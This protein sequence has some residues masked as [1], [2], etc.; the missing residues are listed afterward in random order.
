MTKTEKVYVEKVQVRDLPAHLRDPRLLC[1]IVAGREIRW[2][3]GDF[4]EPRRFFFDGARVGYGGIKVMRETWYSKPEEGESYSGEKY[5]EYLAIE[6]YFNSERGAWD[7][8]SHRGSH[9]FFPEQGRLAWREIVPSDAPTPEEEEA[10]QI[11]ELL[12]AL[13][14]ALCLLGKVRGFSFAAANES[15]LSALGPWK[16]II[17]QAQKRLKA[18]LTRAQAPA[19]APPPVPTPE[20]PAPVPEPEPRVSAQAPAPEPPKQ[21]PKPEPA[22]EPKAAFEPFLATVV[23]GAR[24]LVARAESGKDY[25]LPQKARIALR[26]GARIRV[27]AVT[28]AQR[29]GWLDGVKNYEKQDADATAEA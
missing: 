13:D 24:G 21:A 8:A 11:V 6:A 10:R 1:E 26:E 25:F 4:S 28:P 23:Q 3:F 12:D 9:D 20:P 22:P 5:H 15:A 16:G 19:P 18:A 14:K 17:E 27:T 29:A 7:W 2:A